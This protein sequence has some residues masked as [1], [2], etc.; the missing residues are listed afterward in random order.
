MKDRILAFMSTIQDEM[1]QFAQEIVR[2]KSITCHERDLA[3][4]IEQKMMKLGYDEVRIDALG[5]VVGRIGN[6]R[7]K[8][9][10]DSH[11]D[12]VEV[13]DTTEWSMDPFGGQIKD[14]KLYGRGAVDMK[15]A[16]AASVYAGYALK[17]LGLLDGKTVYIST[18]VMEE[19]FDGETLF[20]LIRE[21]Q[22]SLDYVV[23]CEPS[24]LQ[25]S[26]GHKGRA[27]F[28]VSMP[29]I[30]AH[31]SAPE[32][33]KNAIYAMTTLIE[34]IQAYA[35]EMQSKSEE[36]GS[37]A[38]T[39]IE[40][41]AA[42]LNAIPHICSIYLDRRMVLGEDAEYIEKEMTFLLE[43][44]E[45]TWEVYDAVGTSWKGAP[46][47]LNSFLPAWEIGLD[48]VLTQ[49]SIQAFEALKGEKPALFKWDF[50][51]N[52][53]ATAGKLGIPTIGFGPGNEKLAHMKDEY[54]PVSDIFDACA[55]Y[56]LL[57]A[58]L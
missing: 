28:K 54:C 48:H 35:L 26:T 55:F 31:G 40:S 4:F 23:I 46:V 36:T 50:S 22:L 51:T 44:T 11:I 25:L 16:V 38:I 33:G 18:S 29:G 14:G 12:T 2:I 57:T 32:K 10:F 34:K 39:K 56:T 49:K 27:I 24:H 30:S 47:I 21:L 6:G 7:T 9:L 1:I 41:D 58:M 52:G 19:D 45:A 8:I 43:G 15:A 17:K 5:S 3:E 37:L 42:S 20:A 53:V 13:K